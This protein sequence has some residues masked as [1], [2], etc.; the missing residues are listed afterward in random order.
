M[1]TIFNEPNAANLTA[2]FR[3]DGYAF[4]VAV[5]DDVKQKGGQAECLQVGLGASR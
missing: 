2:S 1:Q 5:A 4:E 3:K